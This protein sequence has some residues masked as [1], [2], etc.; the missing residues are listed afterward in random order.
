MTT[1]EVHRA[2]AAIDREAR[3]RVLATLARRFGDLDL[4]EDM[5]Q[6][7]LA[8][9][10]V[11]WP[12]TG[13]P[14]SP[15]A[16]LKTI[17]KRKALDVVRRE[18]VLAHKVSMLR[19]EEERAPVP[20]AATDPAEAVDPG[21]EPV[22]DERL[23]LFFACAH[24]VLV[25]EERMALTLRFLA[26]LSTPEVAHALLVPVPTMQQR[27]VRAKKRI[28]TL[29]VPLG[30]PRTED[31][32]TR[33]AGVA[34]VVYLLHA[35]GFASSVGA[36]HV[37]DDLT[38]EAIRLARLLRNLMPASA[39]ATGL[40]ALL[41]LTQARRPGRIDEHG[42]PIPLARQDRRRWDR[43]LIAEGLVLAERAA[44]GPGASRYAIQAA[45]AAVHA[46]AATFEETDWPQIA[47]LYGLLA[48]SEPSPVVR[49]GWA[50]AVGRAHGPAIG[51][52]RLDELADDR[53]VDR[54]RHYHVARAVTL[55]EL[56]EDERAATAYRRALTL[57]GNEAENDYLAV[58]LAGLEA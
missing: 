2:V 21:D 10:L 43:D 18:S 44:A 47:V 5:T 58:L 1:E 13:V 35:A 55:A 17:A 29:G 42:R 53:R 33:F 40:L 54:F 20:A 16:W 39:E 26:G 45:I 12:S 56:G 3:G 9:A 19:V 41:L 50:V 48:T 52:A 11:T 27:I 6:E 4:A 34:Q 7:A 51:L 57:P 22:S 8:Q 38:D 32:P 14:V 23:G 36:T 25:P 24:P 30:M 49:I 46:E 31:V 28:R 37:R 15:E